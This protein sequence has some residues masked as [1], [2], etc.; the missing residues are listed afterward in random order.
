MICR[1]LVDSRVDFDPLTQILVLY[2]VG[3][4][5]WSSIWV[6]VLAGLSLGVAVLNGDGC[7]YDGG[8]SS[9]RRARSCITRFVEWDLFVEPSHLSFRSSISSSS[10]MGLT[11]ADLELGV[12]VLLCGGCPGGVGSSSGRRDLRCV[13]RFVECDPFVK[14][15][16]LSFGSSISFSLVMYLTAAVVLV[17]AQLQAERS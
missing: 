9:G 8:S 10:V 6:V 4:F 12:D 7:P 16:R 2:E 13:L 14:T 11:I 1:M 17:L 3:E 5:V 15:S